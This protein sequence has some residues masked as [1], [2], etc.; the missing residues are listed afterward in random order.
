MH[1]SVADTLSA[2]KQLAK[3]FWGE[4][5]VARFMCVD[6]WEHEFNTLQIISYIVKVII[7]GVAFD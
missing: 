3:I 1:I 2:R 6:D 5:A 7:Q 4:S